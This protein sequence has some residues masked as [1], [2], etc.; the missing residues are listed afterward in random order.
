MAAAFGIQTCRFA[1]YVNM[2][3]VESTSAQ[4]Q[5]GWHSAVRALTFL[6]LTKP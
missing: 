5:S 4:K 3:N 1:E 6:L 2:L